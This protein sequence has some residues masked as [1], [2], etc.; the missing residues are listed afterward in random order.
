M[1][2][3]VDGGTHWTQLKSGIPGVPVHDIQI[4]ARANDLVVGTHGRGIYILDDLTPLEH[5]AKAKPAHGRVPL[6]DPGR[7][8]LQPNTRRSS[9]WARADSRD[10]TRTLARAS[11]I[12]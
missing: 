12:C 1:Y 6:P 7:A 5:L 3:T 4:Q 10:R 9:G 2:F 8:A 11:R